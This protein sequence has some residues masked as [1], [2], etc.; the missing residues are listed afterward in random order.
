MF[1]LMLLLL[2]IPVAYGEEPV[3]VPLAK[4]EAADIRLNDLISIR[5]EELEFLRKQYKPSNNHW[6][7][8]GGFLIG[9]ATS[10][11]IMYAVK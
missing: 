10:I 7:T 2:F 1:G 4:S 8:A 11:G 9:A 3:F 6:W 5:G